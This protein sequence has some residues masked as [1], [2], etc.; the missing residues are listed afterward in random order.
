MFL[1]D[2]HGIL[3]W[4]NKQWLFRR[5]DRSCRRSRHISGDRND[6][7]WRS[8]VS[9]RFGKMMM[10]WFHKKS[11]IGSQTPNLVNRFFEDMK[12][13]SPMGFRKVHSH[14][15]HWCL[16]LSSTSQ[17]CREAPARSTPCKCS[18]SVVILK[19][20][21]SRTLVCK[22]SPGRRLLQKWMENDTGFPLLL[23]QPQHS[24]V[25]RWTKSRDQ[26]NTRVLLLDLNWTWKCKTILN[27]EGPVDLYGW[28]ISW[29]I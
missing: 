26:L 14:E 27:A 24:Q 4:S 9:F 25:H 21:L 18:R 16:S 22:H 2:I 7:R 29:K 3:L 11:S 15:F 19:T 20:H 13:L 28:D 23:L 6:E 17:G 12:R 8:S 5:L 1:L 10:L